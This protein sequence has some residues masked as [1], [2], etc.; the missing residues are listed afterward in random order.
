MR[1]I[2]VDAVTKIH[3]GSRVKYK[4]STLLALF[5]KFVAVY[6]L[7]DTSLPYPE[8]WELHTGIVPLQEDVFDYLP[9]NTAMPHEYTEFITL[10]M[11]NVSGFQFSDFK[12]KSFFLPCCFSVF[13]NSF[14]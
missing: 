9:T 8:K 14:G 1:E 5:E 2:S 10:T 4:C 3:S 12:V 7:T 11:E 13:K 6:L